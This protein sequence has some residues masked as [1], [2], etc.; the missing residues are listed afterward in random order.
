MRS[1]FQA[2]K[3][4]FQTARMVYYTTGTTCAKGQT[5]CCLKSEGDSLV[6]WFFVQLHHKTGYFG[7]KE[8]T[9][10]CL[11]TL[12]TY[13]LSHAYG[14]HR[15]KFKLIQDDDSIH[16]AR[17]CTEWFPASNTDVLPWAAKPFDLN[18]IEN[19]WGMMAL[20]VHENRRQSSTVQE[21]RIAV[22]ECWSNFKFDLLPLLLSSTQAY[23]AVFK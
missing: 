22:R 14:F 2:R 11:N 19:L 13:V 15:E 20:S 8:T 16:T 4:S 3:S 7:E 23:F 18:S 21:L 6:R 5:F 1:S 10:E 9:E 17:N 12:E